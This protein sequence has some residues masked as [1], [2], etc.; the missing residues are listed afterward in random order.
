VTVA[1]LVSRPTFYGFSIILAVALLGG[2]G[3][4]LNLQ[5]DSSVPVALVQTAPLS[6]GV[7]YDDALRNH[8]YT[9][10]SSERP[11]WVIDSGNSQVAMF[12]RVLTSTFTDV[13]VLD[14]IPTPQAPVLLDLILAP[15]IREMQF[16]TPGETYFD[17]YEAWIRYDIDLLGSDGRSIG[18]WE[19]TAY[20]KA[21][22]KR[23]ATTT[24]GLNDAIGM[25][26]RDVGAKL[27]IGILEQPAVKQR[28][29]RETAQSNRL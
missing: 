17:F 12:D 18:N 22:K 8:S 6:V 13:V 27:S 29:N 14:N 25:A 1:V 24:A 16:G 9:E 15:R 21:P 5:V 2:C 26:L 11:N 10:D 20:G 4:S 23:F 28:L 7:Y 19:I 3:S